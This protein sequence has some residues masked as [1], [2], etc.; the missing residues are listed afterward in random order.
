MLKFK[1]AKL[2]IEKSLKKKIEIIYS[3]NGCKAS[4]K[5]W[6]IITQ[7]KTNLVCTLCHTIKKVYDLLNFKRIIDDNNKELK[8]N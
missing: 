3:F 4:F 7:D 6:S 8:I 1:K 2:N 5:P